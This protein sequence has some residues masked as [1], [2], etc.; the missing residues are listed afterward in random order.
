[1]DR[2][3]I[4]GINIS[5]DK[6]TTKIE[7]D[8]A[9]NENGKLAMYSDVEALQAR[10]RELEEQVRNSIPKPEVEVTFDDFHNAYYIVVNNQRCGRF[11]Y[12]RIMANTLADDIRQALGL[13]GGGDE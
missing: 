10:V 2:Y 8:Y 7:V 5:I 11:I 6:D 12:D 13:E 9:K 3:E 4:V 1:M